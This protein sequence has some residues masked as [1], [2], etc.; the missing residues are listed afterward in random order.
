[1]NTEIT[2]KR[3]ERGWILY[4]GS[5]KI[6]KGIVRRWNS[7]LERRGFACVPLQTD[8]VRDRLNLSEDEL[9]L[10]MRVLESS[11]TVVGGAAAVLLL[12]GRFWWALPLVW[13]AR[14]PGIFR[15]LDAAYRW[16]AARRYCAN[17]TCTLSPRKRWYVLLLPLA[18]LL[19]CA[20]VAPWVLMWA[21]AGALWFALRVLTLIEV[22]AR[23]GRRKDA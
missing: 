19:F 1:V 7:A 8:W 12:A 16:G 11:G 2:D 20:D 14:L 15:L 23:R 21:M 4:D 17:G 3:G 13:L 18:V 5:C 22:G 10:E 6:C 9:M